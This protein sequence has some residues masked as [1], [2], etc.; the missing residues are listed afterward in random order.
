MEPKVLC[1]MDFNA[2]SP[3]LLYPQCSMVLYGQQNRSL[4]LAYNLGCDK[5]EQQRERNGKQVRVKG[6][7]AAK[8]GLGP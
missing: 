7:F 6:E 8:S 5:R 1:N 3:S 2:S 4:D